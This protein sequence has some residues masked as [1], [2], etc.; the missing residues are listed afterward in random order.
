MY[1][2]KGPLFFGSITHFKDQFDVANDPQDVVIDFDNSR[3]W[4]SSGIDALDNL[5]DKYEQQGKKLH[6][7]HISSDCRALLKKANKFVE[8]NVVE[9]PRY[10]VASDQLG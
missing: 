8:I 6:I 10:K 7:R 1:E 4:D 3:I 5:A 2:L 9:D